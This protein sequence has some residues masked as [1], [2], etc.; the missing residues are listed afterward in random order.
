LSSHGLPSYGVVHGF[1]GSVVVHDRPAT[2]YREFLAIDT[3]ISHLNYLVQHNNGVFLAPWA[4]SESWT[5]SVAHTAA[6][7]ARLIENMN[8]LGGLLDRTSDAVSELF[9]LGGVA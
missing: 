7:G 4:K 6:D 5:L 1:K 2:N 9:E 8:R 3:A